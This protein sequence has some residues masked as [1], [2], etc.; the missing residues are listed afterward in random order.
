MK[1]NNYIIIWT[2][3]GSFLLFGAQVCNAQTKIDFEARAVEYFIS[4]I[5]PHDRNFRNERLFIPKYT[6]GTPS[7]IYD[8]A[9]AL[10]EINILKDSIPNKGNLDSSDKVNSN[11]TA[12]FK[13]TAIKGRRII[14]PFKKGKYGIKIYNAISYNLKSY[15]EIILINSKFGEKE[16]ICVQFKNGKPAKF[17]KRSLILD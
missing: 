8:I 10:G 12:L 11:A 13:K 17:Y 4:K 16:I 9:Y 14:N 2:V 3:F 15:V 5:V 7:N 1:T 6:S